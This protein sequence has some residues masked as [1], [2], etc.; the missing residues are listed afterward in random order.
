MD[1]TVFGTKLGWM[2]VAGAERGVTGV[3]LPAD[4][5]GSALDGLCMKLRIPPGSMREVE[6]AV[7]GTLVDRLTAFMRGEPVAFPDTLDTSGWTDFR[8]RVWSAARLIPYGQ[9]RSYAWVAAAAGQPTAARA[10]GQAMHANPVPIL[11]PCHRV[12][13]SNQSLTGFGGGLALKQRLLALESA[14][15]GA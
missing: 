13:G 12:I 14:H 15:A 5:V 10:V 9:T 4:D 2:A 11:V 6:P 7:F 3:T 1:F 8:T